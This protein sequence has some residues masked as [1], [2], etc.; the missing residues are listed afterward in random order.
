LSI[1][2]DLKIPYNHYTGLLL[3]EP[4]IS[5]GVAKGDYTTST[6]RPDSFVFGS[7]QEN[8][9]LSRY[10]GNAD[11]KGTL[12]DFTVIGSLSVQGYAHIPV[13][14]RLRVAVISTGDELVPEGTVLPE[15]KI[16]DSNDRQMA[17]RAMT[18]VRLTGQA[19]DF[20]NKGR[21]RQDSRGAVS[22][23]AGCSAILEIPPGAGPLN[24]GDEVDVSLF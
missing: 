18:L 1:A 16:Y 11:Y 7:S 2:I 20:P 8:L 4:P 23:L 3:M 6:E 10:E 21:S 17:A 14:R 15:G 12:V 22:I 9:E 24:A 13:Y 5:I 19:V